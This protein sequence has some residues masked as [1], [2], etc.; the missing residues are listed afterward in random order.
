MFW[1]K[2]SNTTASILND[3]LR[4]LNKL[5][6]RVAVLE[7]EENGPEL[8]SYT[9][10]PHYLGW[11]PPKKTDVITIRDALSAVICHLGVEIQ[12][13]PEIASQIKAVKIK[14]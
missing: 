14:K 7:S 1:K 5:E 12:K 9:T 2:K 11:S 6:D 13:T 3:I 8:W 4:K 10:N